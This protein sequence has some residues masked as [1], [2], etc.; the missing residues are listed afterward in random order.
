[1]LER[2]AAVQIIWIEL[3]E[4]IPSAFSMALLLSLRADPRKRRDNIGRHPALVY[5]GGHRARNSPT[6]HNSC[7]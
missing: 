3:A 7:S 2:V 6:D 1:M 5:I 4:N